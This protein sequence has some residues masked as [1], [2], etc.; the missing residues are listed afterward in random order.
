MP[1]KGKK[2]NCNLRFKCCHLAT[3][4]RRANYRYIFAPCHNQWFRVKSTEDL[5]SIAC[6]VKIVHHINGKPYCKN[7]INTNHSSCLTQ[8]AKTA[9]SRYIKISK[10]HACMHACIWESGRCTKC[11]TIN[12]INTFGQVF[13]YNDI[14]KI[15]RCNQLY[16][17]C[18]ERCLMFVHPVFK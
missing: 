12:K 2:W 18:A 15:W 11:N 3:P 13:K 1:L 8:A 5:K 17:E 4:G 9:V 14:R 16:S 10:A 7:K 6:Y